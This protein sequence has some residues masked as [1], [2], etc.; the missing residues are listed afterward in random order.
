MYNL[1]V[2]LHYT[3]HKPVT[4]VQLCLFGCVCL[5]NLEC[6]GRRKKNIKVLRA[7]CQ[8]LELFYM[9]LQFLLLFLSY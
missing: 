7:S 2:M 3:D 6:N 4:K 5:S 1:V 9:Y 8:H